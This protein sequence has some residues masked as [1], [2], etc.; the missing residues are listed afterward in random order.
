MQSQENK[1]RSRSQS[2]S[3][4]HQG[5]VDEANKDGDK[6]SSLA[7][8]LMQKAGLEDKCVAPEQVGTKGSNNIR[9]KPQPQQGVDSDL[10]MSMSSGADDNDDDGRGDENHSA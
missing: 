5:L 9:C 4:L 10:N 6:A 7:S 2:E 8:T 3:K 1:I